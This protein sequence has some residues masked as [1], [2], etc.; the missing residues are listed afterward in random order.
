METLHFSN[1]FNLK[2]YVIGFPR[3]KSIKKTQQKVPFQSL[4]D[5]V[6]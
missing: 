4:T 2:E 6:Q 5:N 1:V 3:L